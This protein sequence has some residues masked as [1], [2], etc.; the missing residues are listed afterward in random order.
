MLQVSEAT[1]TPYEDKSFF[2]KNLVWSCDNEARQLRE[3]A[4]QPGVNVYHL[5]V[6]TFRFSLNLSMRYELAKTRDGEDLID[7]AVTALDIKELLNS[8]KKCG[9]DADGI[10]EII[11]M[12]LD[13]YVV[14]VCDEDRVASGA[15][16]YEDSVI[17]YLEL[18]AKM[19]RGH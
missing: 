11:A 15:E 18:Q 9:D 19:A 7:R 14:G 6:D 10:R 4:C 8:V 13:E 17:D 2:D 12:Q 3:I 1:I 5:L 16:L